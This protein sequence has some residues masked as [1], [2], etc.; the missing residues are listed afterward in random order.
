MT[1]LLGMASDHPPDLTSPKFFCGDFSKKDSISKNSMQPGR[2][3]HLF[4][5]HNPYRAVVFN[6]G[7]AK[8]SL[9]VRKIKTKLK[10]NLCGFGPLANY[11]D[12]AT[13]ASWRSSAN[14]CG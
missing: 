5:F 7:Y 4:A 10:K 11:A 3:H 12:R 1:T 6:L 14:V 13:A 2:H 8:T 9:G